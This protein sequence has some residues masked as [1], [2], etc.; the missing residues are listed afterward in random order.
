M[1]INVQRCAKYRREVRFSCTSALT[2]T[3]AE[4]KGC[5]YVRQGCNDQKAL[6]SILT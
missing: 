4:Q 6:T 2:K 1:Y 5:Q 3:A